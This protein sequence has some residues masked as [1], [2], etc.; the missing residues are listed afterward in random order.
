VLAG[1]DAL[2]PD[3]LRGLFDDA[4][5]GHWDTSTYEAV[6]AR[7]A[8]ETDVLRRIANTSCRITRRTGRTGRPACQGE[9]LRP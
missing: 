3:V 9:V 7:G 4:I 2:P 5:H 6:V 8:Q 1:V